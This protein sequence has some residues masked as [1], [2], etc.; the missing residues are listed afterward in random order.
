MK[1]KVI[2]NA[3]IVTN[4]THFVG[5]VVIDGEIITQVEKGE[6]PE[7]L[8]K[9]ADEV[10][11]A[12]GCYLLPGVID[13][14]V[15]FREPGLTHKADIESESK[16]AVAGGVTSYMEMP[17]TVPQT[18]TLEA[19]EA[20]FARAAEVSVANY[21]FYIGATNDNIDTLL[22][23]D[24]TRVPGVKLFL[25]SSTGN[26]LVDEM[27]TL[28]RIFGEVPAL[29]VVHAEDENI[30]RRNRAMV[31][32]K[33]GE[34]APIELHP[35]IRSAEA[36]YNSTDLAVTLARRYAHRTHIAH[37]TT[38][39]EF[40]L[41][42]NAGLSYKVI[43]SEVCVPHL[44]WC[45][46]DYAS[47]GAKI[48]CNPAIKRREERDALRMALRNERIDIVATDHAPHL[49]SEKQGGALKATSGMPMIQFSLPVMLELVRDG[50]YSIE[51]VVRKM[52]HNPAIL[53]GIE[54][55]GY[56]R[57]GFYADLTIVDTDSC[58][59]VT[60]ADVISKCGWT[61]VVGMTLHSKVISTYVNGHRA[62]HEGVFS[63]TKN[64]KE[65]KFNRTNKVQ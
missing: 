28:H 46:D 45:S 65:L 20:K 62:Y 12:G 3:V 52:S 18:T 22:A 51:E 11:D 6:A 7:N 47:L 56:I 8:L 58:H 36:C 16:A 17:N 33:Y 30:I 37:V 32:E 23:C 1:R 59:T 44:L 55:R 19:L 26:M 63:E 4:N 41:L 14:H 64:A 60:D 31:E 50:V 2:H 53:Y 49:L 43:T 13:G 54:Q 35:E 42:Y 48:K 25:G 34:D 24:Y 10:Q 29:I 61:P 57:P 38:S 9:S 21:A 15:H 27:D 40:K 5:Y 39:R